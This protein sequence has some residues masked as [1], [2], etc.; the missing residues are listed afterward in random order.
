MKAISG[1][2]TFDDKDSIKRYKKKQFFLPSQIKDWETQ[3]NLTTRLIALLTHEDR[4]AS[5]AY[6]TDLD[7][8][9]QNKRTL[10]MTFPANK[11]MQA[12]IL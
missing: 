3:L 5:E 12:K 6:C 10:R 9:N 2:K 7:L 11:L 1:G 4:I 8:Y